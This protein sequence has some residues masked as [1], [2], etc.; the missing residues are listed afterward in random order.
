MEPSF[1]PYNEWLGIEVES[2]E[3]PPNHYRLLGIALFESDRDVIQAAADQR[4]T[5]LQALQTGPHSAEAQR[6]LNSVIGA[7]LCLLK[8]EAKA[9]YDAALVAK[10]SAKVWTKTDIA[11]T[12]SP[13]EI[14][15]AERRELA[16][17]R[18]RTI[19]AFCLVILAASL[20]A[21]MILGLL[22]L[23]R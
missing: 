11:R 12:I 17:A 20:V 14:A 4:M 1:N 22:W 8:P 19:G 5:R 6:L 23:I 3:L 15:A 18:M 16:K 13:V 7:K 21:A 10:V 2:V 9:R